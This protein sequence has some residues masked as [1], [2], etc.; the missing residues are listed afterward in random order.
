MEIKL[1]MH[2]PLMPN[3]IKAS[4][5]KVF[6]N[7]ADLEAATITLPISALT[8]E[9]ANDYAELMRKEF[10]KHWEKATIIEKAN[11]YKPPTGLRKPLNPKVKNDT[12]QRS[13]TKI[14]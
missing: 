9:Q 8:P 6:K 2:P 11:N 3:F 12:C 4:P 14:G 1:T 7:R 13:P 10:I 5:D